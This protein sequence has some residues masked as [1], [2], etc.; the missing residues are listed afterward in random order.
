MSLKAIREVVSAG[1]PAA[2]LTDETRSCSA[3]EREKLLEGLQGGMRVI[4]TPSESLA[5]K[6]D[7]IL[8]W[9]KMRIV[10]RYRTC[11]KY[12]YNVHEHV[13]TCIRY[14][15]TCIVCILRY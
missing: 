2:Q 7:L 3:A 13:H 5:M 1:S 11:T 4:I 9:H 10:R 12:T 6:A 14:T 15:Y 8:P